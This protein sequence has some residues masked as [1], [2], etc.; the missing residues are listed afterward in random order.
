MY[1]IYFV[2]SVA[3]FLPDYKKNVPMQRLSLALYTILFQTKPFVCLCTKSHF[4]KSLSLDLYKLLF[5]VK[6]LY[7]MQSSKCLDI[8]ACFVH[9]MT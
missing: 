5:H 2:L 3:F 7:K 1:F 6:A 8:N 4:K 9:S